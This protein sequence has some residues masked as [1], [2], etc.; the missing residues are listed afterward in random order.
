[1]AVIREFQDYSDERGNVIVGKA[2]ACAKSFIDFTAE[3]CRIEIG[4]GVSFL[5]AK[6]RMTANNGLLRIGRQSAIKNSIRVGLDSAVL[7]G[8]RLSCTGGGKISAAEG[9][10]VTIGDDCMFAVSFDIRSDHAHPI[11]D[12]ETG[13]RVNESKSL[14]IGDHVWLGPHA[15]IY[16]GAEVG[17]GCVIGARS[18]VTGPIPPHSI[19][20]GV[21]ARVTRRN[22]VWD[23]AHL[24]VKP[25]WRFDHIADLG[26]SPWQSEVAPEAIDNC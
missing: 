8:E 13:L 26:H 17:E 5:N 16:P 14:S 6:I 15:L 23:K 10:V 4:D 24:C 1:V 18:L 3:N 11:F 22:I 7:I 19:A 12:R 25:P 21:P 9:T 2:S 20:V